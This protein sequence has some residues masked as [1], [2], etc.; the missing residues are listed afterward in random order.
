MVFAWC[1]WAYGWLSVCGQE[2]LFYIFCGQYKK[3]FHLKCL[4]WPGRIHRHAKPRGCGATVSIKCLTA[5]YCLVFDIYICSNHT[6]SHSHP[7]THTQRIPAY[8]SICVYPLTLPQNHIPFAGPKPMALLHPV[9]V[10]V[11][12]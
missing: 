12:V 5:F 8:K 6:H 3:Q 11:F 9:A 4:A 1:V 2:N 10:F 7:H